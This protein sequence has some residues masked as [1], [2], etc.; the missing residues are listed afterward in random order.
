MIRKIN[1]SKGCTWL[2]FNNLRLAVGMTL[3]FYIHVVKGLKL[4][5]RKFWGLISTF[6]EVAEEKLVETGRGGLF[7][8]HP[9]PP[10][11]D[12]VKRNRLSLG[13]KKNN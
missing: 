8:H 9:N 13:F 6:V 5:Y 3:Q 1:F 4:N 2:K 11:L 12:S 7:A 10:I